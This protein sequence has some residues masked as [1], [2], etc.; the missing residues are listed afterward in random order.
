M[1]KRLLVIVFALLL[2]SGCAVRVNGRPVAGG[3]P[4]PTTTR[5]TTASTTAPTTAT[6][7]T[8][9]PC[10]YAEDGSPGTVGFPPST[11]N[12]KA[13]AL[14]FTTDR[15]D[16]RVELDPAAGPCSVQAVRYLVGKKFYDGTTCHRLTTNPNLG[17][18][19]CGDPTGT[20]TGTPGFRFDDELPARGAYARGVVAMANAGPGTNGSQ[21]FIVHGAAQINPD[22]PVIGKVVAGM[23]VVDQVVAGGVAGGAEDGKPTTPLSFVRVT[24]G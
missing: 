23:E 6:S 13:S 7:G 18:L 11:P 20:G 8:D 16:V 9:G 15:G 24:E 4:V 14:T 1:P 5:S 2:L 21:F 12:P 17:V 22:Y 19:Q 10:E 3:A